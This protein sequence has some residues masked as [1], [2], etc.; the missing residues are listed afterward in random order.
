[1]NITM[2][3]ENGEITLN[4][5]NRYK[6]IITLG[7][8]DYVIVTRTGGIHRFFKELSAR[9]MIVRRMNH[10]RHRKGFTFRDPRRSPHA[11]DLSMYPPGGHYSTDNGEGLHTFTPE[12]DFIIM[13]KTRGFYEAWRPTLLTNILFEPGEVDILQMIEDRR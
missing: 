7:K 11:I 5:G 9:E 1:V 12:H 2:V 6:R 4:P 10:L 8:C 3:V 13:G